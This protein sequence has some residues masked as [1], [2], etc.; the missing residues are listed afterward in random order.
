[1]FRKMSKPTMM[2]VV[3]PS[4]EIQPRVTE[5]MLAPKDLPTKSQNIIDLWFQP[6]SD[7]LDD[8]RLT[9][10]LWNVL[11]GTLDVEG[12]PKEP[13]VSNLSEIHTG[14]QGRKWRSGREFRLNSL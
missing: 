9:K 1:M 7:I 5:N 12:S 6:F 3:E 14:V 11:N 10:K 4:I 2:I 13:I 8:E